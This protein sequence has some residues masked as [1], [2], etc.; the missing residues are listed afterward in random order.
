[1]RRSGVLALVL[2]GLLSWCGSPADAQEPRLAVT[3]D[4]SG[5]PT[6]R[7]LGAA[8]LPEGFSEEVTATGI[9]GATAMAVAS[10][11]RVFV[12]E[13]TGAL[14]IVKNDVLLPEPFVTVKVDSLWERG[15]IGVALDP[16]FPKQPLRLPLLR[17]RGSISAPSR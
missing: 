13:Q 16:G 3:P 5:P 9:T 11:G 6:P 7:P 1:M 15:L 4:S 10:D 12:C 2:F 17:R 8:E 14:R